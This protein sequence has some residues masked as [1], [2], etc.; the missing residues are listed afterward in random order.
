MKN[1]IWYKNKKC[2]IEYLWNMMHKW[3]T[4]CKKMLIKKVMKIN[5]IKE[6]KVKKLLMILWIKLKNNFNCKKINYN[7]VKNEH[8]LWLMD[9]K[10]NWKKN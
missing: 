10:N 6:K 5:K 1:Q 7:F 4:K 8:N 9:N 3:V 2:N